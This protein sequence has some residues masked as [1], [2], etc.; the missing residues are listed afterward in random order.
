MLLRRRPL[1]T[2]LLTTLLSASAHGQGAPAANDELSR[3]VEII[4][5]TG[6]VPHV[7]AANL[8][9]AGYALGWL[10]LEDYGP[11][12]AQ[13]VLR[14]SGRMGLVFG[15]DS[16][17][18][19]FLERLTRA[20]AV[21]RYPQ[22]E[23]N[24]REVYEGFAAGL[25]RYITL[26]RDEF[27]PAMP[28]DFTGIDILAGDMGGPAYASVRR[29]LA[30]LETP[31]QRNGTRGGTRTGESV[32]TTAASSDADDAGA[33]AIDNVG[34]NAWAFAPSR[35]TSGKA[36]LLRNPH[37]AW[38]AGYYEAHVT[39]PGHFDFYGDFRIGGPLTLIGGFNAHLGWSTTNNAQ[40]LQELYALDVDPADSDR[41]LLDGASHALK[42]ETVVVPYRTATGTSTESR[43]F[44]FA[45]FGPVVHRANGKLY[46]LK[47]ANDGEYRNGE[48]FLRMMHARSL[49][50][51]KAAMR[52][53]ARA[54]SNFT[55]ADQ[56]GN[57]LLVWNAALPLLPHPSGGDTLAIP[58]KRMADIW[59][60]YVPWDSLPQFLNPA[61]GY[62]H[63][64]NSSPHFTNVRQPVD[65][66]NRY[67]NFEKP[68]LSL[69]SQLALQLVG[70]DNRLSLEDVVTLKHSYRMLL[71]DRVK[72][73]LIAAIV[74]T[75][76]SGELADGLRLLEQWDNTASA[77]SPGAMLFETWWNRYAQG[78][79][80]S[81]RFAKPWTSAD[82]WHT[83]SGLAQPA[84]AAEAFAWAVGETQKR[85][86]RLDVAWGAVHRVRRGAVDVPVGGCSG[87]L[88]CFRVLNFQRDADGKL[89][90][91]GGDGWIL[92]VEFGETPRAYSV[93]AYGNSNRPESPWFATQAE[94]FAKGQLKPVAYSLADIEKAAVMRYHPGEKR[95]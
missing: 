57:I 46:V 43:E 62:V 91:N 51:W 93:L 65:T 50:E 86:G 45:D 78:L 15:R 68:S 83:P 23:A 13:G 53:H 18:S 29:Y 19:D 76:P 32:N 79:A 56:A 64:E 67:P 31:A 88:G 42:R 4:R 44:W 7:R 27:A 8:R 66:V 5:T 21:E 6:G 14:S 48:Q 84:R 82:A 25:N 2:L 69:R 89:A 61:G 41:Y 85:Y 49:A 92:A 3:D 47:T 54:T 17:E 77:E 90:A 60:R 37:L 58:A 63:N 52:L 81:L 74:S 38:S 80:D 30:K 55:Y 39:V 73:D 20:R 94:M 1:A 33:R 24:T 9:A 26:H 40:V 12:T 71:A 72:P 34:S 16:L 95:D 35:T 36:I 70:G 22:L 28:T 87:A 59:T 10:M 75:K 11:R